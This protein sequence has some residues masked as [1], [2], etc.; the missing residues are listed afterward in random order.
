MRAHDEKLAP[1][2]LSRAA[3][4]SSNVAAQDHTCGCGCAW[5]FPRAHN[6]ATDLGR[7]HAAAMTPAALFILVDE[8]QAAR[9]LKAVEREREREG[10]SERD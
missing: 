2:A 10:E 9:V 7:R 5:G 8:A 4:L 3:A 1:R 6:H